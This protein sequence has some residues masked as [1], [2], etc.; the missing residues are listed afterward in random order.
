MTVPKYLTQNRGAISAFIDKYDVFLCDCDGVLWS[1]DYVFPGTVHTLELL[2]KQNKQVLFVTNNSTKSRQEYKR[3]LEQIGLPTSIEEIFGSSY[4]ASV[5]IARIL[6]QSYPELKK[7]NKVF[8]I[9]EAGIETELDAEAIPYLGGTDS[10]YRR[11]MTPEDYQLLAAGDP[12]VLDPYVGAVLVGLDFHFNHLKVCYAYHYIRRGALF[13]A[14]NLDST[15]P[16]AG[17]LF[18]GAGSVVA[19]LV[20]MLGG[21]E[22][23]VFG[24]P[25]QAMMDA[26]QEK[27]KFD[28]RKAC[29]VGDQT[30]TDIRF[31]IEGKLGGT[32]GVLTGVATKH[33]F[34]DDEFR[35]HYYI[36][37]LG[38]LLEGA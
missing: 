12:S 5:F 35:P 13:L 7:R 22:P 33:D 8:V 6:P 19:P 32:L 31:G 3:K 11:E 23:L 21:Q 34:F 26:I 25:N 14:T 18:P 28:P 30:S 37:K 16:S 1:G 36:D 29:M 27:V 15:I 24:K 10:T 4:S 17:G 38:D 20:K 9:G 2:R